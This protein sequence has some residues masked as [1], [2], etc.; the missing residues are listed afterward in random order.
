M[1]G[2]WFYHSQGL[3]LCLCPV[4]LT[5]WY[6]GIVG[7][8]SLGTR[9]LVLP[10]DNRFKGRAVHL[11]RKTGP[12]GMGARGLTP[13]F[14]GSGTTVLQPSQFALMGEQPTSNQGE[15]ALPLTMVMGLILS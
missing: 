12:S 6:H 8:G 7:L 14:N 15:M 10:L 5:T 3:H 13:D 2:W 4:V 11:L 9:E 1:S